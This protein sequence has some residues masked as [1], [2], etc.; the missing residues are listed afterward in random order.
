MYLV[1]VDTTPDNKIAKM[2]SYENRSEADAHVA[3][4]LPNYPDAF[5]VDNPPSYV[6]DY[7]TVDVAAKTITY[8]SSGFDAQKVKDDAQN[9]INRL[10]GTVTARR[11]REA[12][13]SDDGK[14]WIAVVEEK[15]KVERAKL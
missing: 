10:E 7:T 3:R 5:I 15:I 1:V 2:Q 12:L 13:A 14:A 11:M 8:D 6:M 9:E 4:V